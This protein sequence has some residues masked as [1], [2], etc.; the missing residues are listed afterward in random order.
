[1]Q[2]YDSLYDSIHRGF[3]DVNPVYEFAFYAVNI[4][5]RSI[6]DQSSRAAN[7]AACWDCYDAKLVFNKMFSVVAN[8]LLS[9]YGNVHLT[10]CDCGD[11]LAPVP[12]VINKLMELSLHRRLVLSIDM[13]EVL[14]RSSIIASCIDEMQSAH[15]KRGATN[16]FVRITRHL[17]HSLVWNVGG[18]KFGS[19]LILLFDYGL[20][21]ISDDDEDHLDL[22]DSQINALRMAMNII[23]FGDDFSE[24]CVEERKMMLRS[25]AR[26]ILLYHCQKKTLM[27][28]Y[29]RSLYSLQP[30][31]YSFPHSKH[32]YCAWYYFHH[33]YLKT[34]EPID[35]AASMHCTDIEKMRSAFEELQYK[36]LEESSDVM[37]AIW[38]MALHEDTFKETV[39]W[40]VKLKKGVFKDRCLEYQKLCDN[41]ICK[42]SNANCFEHLGLR[43][44]LCSRCKKRRY[45]S[46]KCQKFDWKFHHSLYCYRCVTV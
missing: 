4:L 44:M 27:E 36:R 22:Q 19:Y 29:A 34:F 25:H 32:D 12:N 5:C 3:G 18:A 33:F 23:L 10:S 7:V 1:M 8:K 11:A 42:E 15:N 6:T 39:N 31:S 46:R 17:S 20:Q 2:Q 43:L 35:K 9:I 21:R 30:H 26:R 37:L 45:C 38:N 16:L 41:V 13:N 40:R 24:T 14:T 28:R